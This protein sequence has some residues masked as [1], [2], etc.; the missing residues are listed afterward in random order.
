MTKE[1]EAELVQCL[2]Q[3]SDVF[4]WSPQDMLGIDPKFMNHKLS[5]VEGARPVVQKKRK[6]GEEK[7]RAIK[8]ETEKL[9]NAGFIREVRYPEW[10]ANVVMVRMANGR[11]RMCTDY[12]DL[13]K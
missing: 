13:N 2:Q 9:L 11:W 6:Q 4:A 1:Q 10:L 12:T 3:N 5:I 7:R 8:E